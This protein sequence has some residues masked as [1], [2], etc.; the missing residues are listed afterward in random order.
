MSYEKHDYTYDIKATLFEE[1]GDE[2]AYDFTLSTVV[3][4]STQI[5]KPRWIGAELPTSTGFMNVLIGLDLEDG[6]SVEFCN[7]AD[8]ELV[9]KGEAESAW[10]DTGILTVKSGDE[11]VFDDNNRLIK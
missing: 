7:E 2:N 5:P 10:V 11:R 4:Y 8:I 1:D 9:E 6:N 3:D